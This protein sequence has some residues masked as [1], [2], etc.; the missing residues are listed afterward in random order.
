MG[1]KICGIALAATGAVASI[2]VGT[3]SGPLLIPILVPIVGVLTASETILTGGLVLGLTSRRKAYYRE[4]CNLIRSYVDRMYLLTEKCKQD[5]VITLEELESFR[6]LMD[7]YHK[8][9]NGIKAP[10]FDID[11]LQ[12][13]IHKELQRD[14]KKE[15]K[16]LVEEMKEKQKSQL[17]S[18]LLAAYSDL[19]PTSPRL[20]LLITVRIPI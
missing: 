9:V 8:E 1:I 15:R 11:K 6:H 14:I 4:K 5:G 17:R 20:L 2:V 18:Q 3:M 13:D 12:K 10:E 7:E 16:E 19:P